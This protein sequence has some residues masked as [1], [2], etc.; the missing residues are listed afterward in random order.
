[1]GPLAL[2]VPEREDFI[3]LNRA[4]NSAAK[5]VP[6]TTGN[7][8]LAGRDLRR[9]LRERIAGKIRVG[10]L[11]IERRAVKFVRAGFGLRSDDS[12]DGF[13]ELGIVVLRS[14]LHLVDGIEVRINYDDS[15]DR[16]LV[17]GA[18]IGRASCRE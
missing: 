14:N 8:V 5:L 16:I 15:E 13:A 18:K 6:I 11:E 7:L 3:L 4:A 12:P 2:V 17:I 1:M 10:T 9:S